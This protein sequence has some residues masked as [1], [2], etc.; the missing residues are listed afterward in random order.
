[1]LDG[2]P[3]TLGQ[4]A[5]LDA[6]LDARRAKL[7][8]VLYFEIT[9]ET[10]VDRL[11]GRRLCPKCNAGYHVAHMPPKVAG[12]CDKCGSGLF[13]RTDDKPETIR[14]RLTVYAKQTSA[15]VAEYDRRGLLRRMDA[16]REPED[17]ASSVFAAL[18]PI[19]G[20]SRS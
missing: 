8:A 19:A 18:D 14:E 17:V 12:R 6:L 11:G 16:N 5:A 1:M 2:F 15:L 7:D 10:A 13:Q 3:R 20:G 9:E 4:A